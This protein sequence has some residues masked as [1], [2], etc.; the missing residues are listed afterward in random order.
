MKKISWKA[1]L[2]TFGVTFVLTLMIFPLF[3]SWTKVEGNEVAVRQHLTRGVVDGIWSSGTHYYVGF[4]WDVYKYDIGIQKITF[5]NDRNNDAEYP[6]IAVEIGANGGQRAYIA[7]SA[8]YRLMPSKVIDLHKQGIGKTYE[9]VLLKREIVDIVNEI[10]RPYPS[11]LDIY[12]G[13]GFVE[14][15]NRVEK[16]LRENLVLKNSGIDIENTIIYGVHLDP[17]YEAEIAAK[18]LAMQQKL[19]KQEETKAAEEEAKRI[20]AMSQA[21]VEKVRQNSEARK[22][23]MVKQA[24]ANAEREVLA[25]QAEKQKRVLEA[26]G[27]RDASLAKAAGIIAEGEA[28]ARVDALKRESLYAGESGAWRAKVEIATAQAEK[29]KNLLTGVQVIP[30]NAIIQIG[31]SSLA[32]EAETNDRRFS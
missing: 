20:F 29:L 10:A 23:E 15:K 6:R 1:K 24:E 14:F 28:Q 21:E 12:S 5:D 22:I 9:A 8:N 30:E 16:A 31:K 32:I 4:F 27:Q 11:A 25:A 18:Q 17:A 13:A 19:R 3:I 7:M 26:E 2:I